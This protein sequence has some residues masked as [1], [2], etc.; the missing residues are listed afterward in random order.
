MRIVKLAG[1]AS[2]LLAAH[3]FAQSTVRYTLEL[4]PF[5]A[6]YV[7]AWKNRA[8][9]SGQWTSSPAYFTADGTVNGA[10]LGNPADGQVFHVGDIITWDLVVEVDPNKEHQAPGGSGPGHGYAPC[11]L[12]NLVF[13]LQ[14]EDP[15][16]DPSDNVITWF[17]PGG[18]ATSQG[19]FSA[20]ND[21]TN[22]DPL[23]A[24]AFTLVYNITDPL[25]TSIHGPGRAIDSPGLASGSHQ[26]PVGG[27]NLGGKDTQGRG[28]FCYP[29]VVGGKLL[30][31]GCGYSTW[32]RSNT[33]KTVQTWAGVGMTQWRAYPSGTMQ[34]GLGIKP[35]CE[36]QINTMGMPP[37]VYRLRALPTRTPTSNTGGVN[38]LRGD[39]DLLNVQNPPAA[40]AVAANV[41][42]EDTITFQ[43]L[44]PAEAP[45]ITAAQSWRTHG[46]AGSFPIELSLASGT[47]ATVECRADE[48]VA[49]GSNPMVVVIF[50]KEITGNPTVQASAIGGPP[51]VVGTVTIDGN[52]L[53][54]PLTGATD[55]TCVT[56]AISDVMGVDGGGPASGSVS[57]TYRYGDINNS[58]SVNVVDINAVR[59][60]SGPEN[61]GW[62]NFWYDVNCSGKVNVSDINI[63]SSLSKAGTVSCVIP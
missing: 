43:L 20:I 19:F 36:G 2:V 24:A 27:P 22:G 32:F 16:A 58:R 12:A 28:T 41:V 56:L 11:G 23:A 53:I 15:N 60:Q 34:T 5:K 39:V 17:G 30:G 55:E 29:T 33:T 63:V 13:N 40:F 52:Q 1:A 48:S 9:A 7:S 42:E 31:Q 26:P 62:D 10:P 6:D 50:D 54:I 45:V 35:I 25:Y 44:P 38:V 61:V 14:L 21:G 8:W 4:S 37:G 49:P 3:V 46:A 59:S 18:S 47:N 51:P 57:L